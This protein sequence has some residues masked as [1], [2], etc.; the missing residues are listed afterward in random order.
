MGSQTL[1]SDYSRN[2]YD[3]ERKIKKK[4]WNHLAQGYQLATENGFSKKKSP[5]PN[6][7]DYIAGLNLCYKRYERKKKYKNTNRQNFI[8]YAN[9]VGCL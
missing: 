9:N 1:N 7:H 5:H 6:V 4:F 3:P 8:Q 2:I